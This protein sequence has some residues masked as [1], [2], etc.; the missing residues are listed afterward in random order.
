MQQ[1]PPTPAAVRPRRKFPRA[2][3]ALVILIG[4]SSYGFKWTVD[5]RQKQLD[6]QALRARVRT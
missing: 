5:R 2:P 3:I 1:R 6:E 4:A